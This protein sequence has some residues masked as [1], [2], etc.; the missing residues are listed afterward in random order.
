MS[1]LKI[2]A[3]SVKYLCNSWGVEFDSGKKGFFVC[4]SLWVRSSGSFGACVAFGFLTWF[5]FAGHGAVD[6]YFDIDGT[7]LED[8]IRGGYLPAWRTPIE[9]YR[10]EQGIGFSEG[11]SDESGSN[12]HPSS[13][14]VFQHELDQILTGLST[15]QGILGSLQ[16][17]SRAADPA[18]DA[19]EQLYGD[20][21][22]NWHEEI[23]PGHYVL[24]YDRSFRMYRDRDMP[25]N[26]LGSGLKNAFERYQS[27]TNKYRLLG[28]AFPYFQKALIELSEHPER[29]SR[30]FLL[31]ARS[32]TQG[33]VQNFLFTMKELGMLDQ[34][35]TNEALAQVKGLFMSSDWA[36]S[37]YGAP[38][39]ARKGKLLAE[40]IIALSRSDRPR[41]KSLSP[42]EH[43]AL[44]NGQREAHEIFY[45][46]DDTKML[47]SAI[48]SASQVVGSL[49]SPVKVTFFH[50]GQIKDVLHSAL[51][52]ASTADPNTPN[53][54]GVLDPTTLK[55]RPLKPREFSSA[56]P[57]RNVTATG[58]NGSSQP[59]VRSNETSESKVK[60]R[61]VVRRQAGTC[62]GSLQTL[63]KGGRS[64]GNRGKAK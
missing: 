20:Y 5:S 64:N 2:A 34:R 7:L 37:S 44:G 56:T 61:G 48:E 6:Y 14:F 15:G 54:F 25:E 41:H 10:V 24:D 36:S 21:G 57:P 45:F 39:E 11:I 27:N 28:L 62:D 4:V 52:P 12:P 1:T 47:G 43:E 32:H 22:Y 59:V 9:L 51:N 23:F 42:V 29:E 26:H 17:F 31:S 63:R 33:S 53:R 19:M 16:S 18:Q 49:P 50:S 55:L 3:E 30:V 58:S 38:F 40:A 60:P 35:I 46:E 8:R 13:V